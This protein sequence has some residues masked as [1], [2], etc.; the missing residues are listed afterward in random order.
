PYGARIFRFIGAAGQPIYYDAFPTVNGV[1]SEQSLKGLLPG[2]RKLFEIEAG[3]E[4]P[5]LSIECDR[6]VPG[7]KIEFDADLK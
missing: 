5:T 6:L 1:R 2:E 3:G 7:Q 4:S